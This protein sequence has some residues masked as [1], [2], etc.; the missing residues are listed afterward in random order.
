MIE[1]TNRFNPFFKQWHLCYYIPENENDALTSYILKFKGEDAESVSRWTNWILDELESEGTVFDYVIRCLSSSEVRA[2]Y[3]KPLDYVGDRISAELNFPYVPIFIYKTR[4]TQK[5]SSMPRKADREAELEGVY[6]VSTDCPNLSGKKILLLDDVATSETTAKAIAKEIHAK[7]PRCQIYLLTLAK[8]LRQE[9]ANARI[10]LEYFEESADNS[11]KNV[12]IDHHYQE[13]EDDDVEIVK[14]IFKGTYVE[15][16]LNDPFSFDGTEESL[17][18]IMESIRSDSKQF[19][20]INEYDD[21]FLKYVLRQMALEDDN[22]DD[23]Y[24]F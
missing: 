11:N 18:E 20:G 15:Y 1:I 21:D 19:T 23:D 10:S 22:E 2:S 9:N 16:L 17:D 3:R 12:V 5:L 6:K 24:P 13:D 14:E 8:T 4:V 7:Y